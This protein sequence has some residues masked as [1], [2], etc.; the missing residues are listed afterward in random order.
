M[1]SEPSDTAREYTDREF[2]ACVC[3]CVCVW[4]FREAKFVHDPRR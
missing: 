3:V 2:V 4:T 1:R